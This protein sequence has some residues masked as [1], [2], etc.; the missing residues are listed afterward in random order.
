MAKRGAESQITKEGLDRGEGVG[1]GADGSD[2][3]RKATAAQL[4]NRK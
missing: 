4:A 1:N 2:T 3:P